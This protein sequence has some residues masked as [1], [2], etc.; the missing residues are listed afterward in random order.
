VNGL[1]A[2]F[3]QLVGILVHKQPFLGFLL[4]LCVYNNRVIDILHDLGTVV[5]A[6]EHNDGVV[7]TEEL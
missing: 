4:I 1:D 5:L 3:R 7:E 6:A 2:S